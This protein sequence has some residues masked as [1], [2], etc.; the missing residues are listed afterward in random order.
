MTDNLKSTP[1]S[2]KITEQHI[3]ST[4]NFCQLFSI[5]INLIQKIYPP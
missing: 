2:H 4:G 3:Q 5:V 1:D